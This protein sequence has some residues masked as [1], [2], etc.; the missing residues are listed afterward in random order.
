MH[1]PL[2][3]WMLNKILILPLSIHYLLLITVQMLKLYSVLLATIWHVLTHWNDRPDLTR[4]GQ[5]SYRR[6]LMLPSVRPAPRSFIKAST[7]TF[8][9]S[10][11]QTMF[12][13]F[14]FILYSKVTVDKIAKSQTPSS[15][16]VPTTSPHKYSNT[17]TTSTHQRYP[18]LTSSYT[19]NLKALQVEQRYFMNVCSV[20]TCV[21]ELY[22]ER[23]RDVWRTVC[24]CVEGDLTMTVL[25]KKRKENPFNFS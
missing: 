24:L 21:G 3:K 14:C 19:Y 6:V 22:I 1:L 9:K 2:Q 23:R 17:R 25:T 5:L 8:S 20:C 18:R 10:L 11:K 13:I 12:F 15:L 16:L 7:T 4:A